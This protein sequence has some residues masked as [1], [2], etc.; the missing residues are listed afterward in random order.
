M[1][2]GKPANE[3]IQ[4]FARNDLKTAYEKSMSYRINMQK[5]ARF[6][7]RY[8]PDKCWGFSGAYESWVAVGG[9]IIIWVVK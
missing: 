2:D 5:L 7:V 1:L 3:L 4:A 9:L 8:A 6:F